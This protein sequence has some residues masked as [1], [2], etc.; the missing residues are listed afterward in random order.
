[1]F[2]GYGFGDAHVNR[3]IENRMKD[4]ENCPT[5]VILDYA[6]K[7][8]KFLPNRDD[9][10][11][12]SVQSTL[13]VSDGDFMKSTSR[14]RYQKLT[15]GEFKKCNLF[16]CTDDGRLAIWYNGFIK[17]VSHIARIQEYLAQGA[18]KRTRLF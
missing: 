5:C 11:V 9:H 17:S 16:E 6:A 10:W 1:M 4:S 13:R 8:G 15:M 14:I 12:G 3:I 18:R 2:C 7:D